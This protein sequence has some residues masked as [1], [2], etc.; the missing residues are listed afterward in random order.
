MPAEKGPPE[1]QLNRTALADHEL[2]MK[3]AEYHFPHIPR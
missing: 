1:A 2:Q 3:L